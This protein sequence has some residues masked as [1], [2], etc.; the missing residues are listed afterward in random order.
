MFTVTNP[1][2]AAPGVYFQKRPKHRQT[3]TSPQVV[4]Y[5]MIYPSHLRSSSSAICPCERVR[6]NGGRSR[7][8]RSR[9]R[10]SP[11]PRMSARVPFCVRE[12]S[13]RKKPQAAWFGSLILASENA[14]PLGAGRNL[15]L[16]TPVKKRKKTKFCGF[17]VAWSGGRR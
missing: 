13:W 7:K 4:N 2:L 10:L 1:S 14:R 6:A 5:R 11:K 16:T 15:S 12:A 8:I 9:E 3:R 17:Y